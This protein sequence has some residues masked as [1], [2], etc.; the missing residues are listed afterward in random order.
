MDARDARLKRNLS[1]MPAWFQSSTECQ[2][3]GSQAGRL[4][5]QAAAHVQHLLV[6]LRVEQ[7]AELLHT[8]AARASFSRQHREGSLCASRFH[9]EE[10]IHDG[11]MMGTW[12]GHDEEMM[13]ASCHQLTQ[14]SS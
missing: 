9:T 10:E 3:S 13:G 4:T 5:A 1:A 6:W 11:E 2:G 12:W 8:R 14:D 7:A